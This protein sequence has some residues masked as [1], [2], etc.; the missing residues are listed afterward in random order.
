MD[1]VNEGLITS[2]EAVQRITVDDIRQILH[3]QIKD[4]KKYTPLVKGLNAAPGAAS[5]KV[6]FDTN[7]AAKMASSKTPIILVRTETSP[8]DIHGIAVAVGVLTQKGGL[9]SHAAVVTR[10]M[11]KPCICGAESIQVDV[12]AGQFTVNGE[13]IK[14]YDEITIDGSTGNVYKGAL[15][16]EEAGLNA[17]F[18]ELLQITDGFKRLGVRANADTPEMIA[19]ARQFGAEGIGLC[20]TERMFNE[21]QR[22]AMIREFIWLRTMKP[23]TMPSND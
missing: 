22:L 4:V 6:I 8:D 17:E 9:T 19:R 7:K 5:G 14:E 12:E 20:R 21:P 16:L 11:G 10:G 1:M 15:P 18:E 13:V 3:K 2:E 23:G